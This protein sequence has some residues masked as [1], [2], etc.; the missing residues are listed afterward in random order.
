MVFTVGVK[1][2]HWTAWT[3]TKGEEKL[4][5]RRELQRRPYTIINFPP[6]QNCHSL[7]AFSQFWKHD[8]I[9]GGIDD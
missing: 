7:Q 4:K 2:L 1:M 5:F 6:S 3:K 8:R 9:A